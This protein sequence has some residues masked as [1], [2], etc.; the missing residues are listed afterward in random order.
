MASAFAMTTHWNRYLGG[1][2]WLIATVPPLFGLCLPQGC[3]I[4]NIEHQRLAERYDS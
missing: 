2:P 1:N 4:L 3:A